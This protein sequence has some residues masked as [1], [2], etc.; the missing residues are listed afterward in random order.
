MCIKDAHTHFT[1]FV[2]RWGLY[3]YTVLLFGLVNAPSGFQ[4][5]MNQVLRA[6]L[7]RFCTV[8][9][10]DILVFSRTEA[11]HQEHLRWVFE[12]LRAH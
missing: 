1:A 10:D 7:D 8:Y 9:L 3:E 6:G 5:L 4:R 12:Q 2:S 11:E